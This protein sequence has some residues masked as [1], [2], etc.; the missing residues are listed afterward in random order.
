MHVVQSLVVPDSDPI[1]DIFHSKLLMLLQQEGK[2]VEDYYYY[3]I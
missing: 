3:A 1:G 2:F